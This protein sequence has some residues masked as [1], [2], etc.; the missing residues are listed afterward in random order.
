M[1]YSNGE[2]TSAVSVDWN[3]GRN[4]TIERANIN[5]IPAMLIH[6]RFIETPFLQSTPLDAENE[7]GR[8]PHASNSLPRP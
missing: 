1:G 5:K 7:W 8:E 2:E 3:R 6:F 4:I